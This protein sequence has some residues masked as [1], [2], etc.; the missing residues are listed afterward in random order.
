MHEGK[1][2]EHTVVAIK[3]T[4]RSQFYSQI[5]SQTLSYGTVVNLAT[6]AGGNL[7]SD[8]EI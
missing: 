5:Y 4:H 3:Y 8:Q 1:N 6:A 7:L 2:V